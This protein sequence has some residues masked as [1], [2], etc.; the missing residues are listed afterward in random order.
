VEWRGRGRSV[1]ASRQQTTRP[2]AENG[3]EVD[4]K[5]WRLGRAVGGASFEMSIDTFVKILSA[6]RFNSVSSDIRRGC[7]ARYP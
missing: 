1:T 5:G 2:C 3:A 6:A 7:R 4:E